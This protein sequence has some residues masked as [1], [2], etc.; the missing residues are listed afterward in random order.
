MISFVLPSFNSAP[1][2][3][4][5]VKSAMDQTYRDCEI[6][7]INDASTDSTE[8]YLTW[9][10]KQKNRFPVHV[11]NSPV[12]LGRSASRN[13]GNMKAS[14]DIC[15]LDADDL[16]TPK[17]ADLTAQAFAEGHK[18]VYG[19]AVMIDA[20][21]RKQGELQ[22]SVFNK[23]KALAEGVN[24]I[25]HSTIGYTKDIA[26]RFPYVMGD[27]SDLGIDDWEQQVRMMLDGVEFA[28]I[29]NTLCAYRI[30]D[31]AISK[32]RDEAKVT[33]FKKDYLERLRMIA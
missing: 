12:N 18:F 9:L 21:G 20:V 2:L 32:T 17:R 28:M 13:L 10:Q 25:V 16:A 23:D 24:R 29:P 27:I 26:E 5:A 22:A 11:I 30:L 14:G 15:V 6:I 1:W 4:Q 7:I 33:A 3:A 31:S 19:S 8:Q